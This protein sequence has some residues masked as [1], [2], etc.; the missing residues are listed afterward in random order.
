MMHEQCHQLRVQGAVDLLYLL[1][2][3][4]L[5]LSTSVCTCIVQ[6]QNGLPYTSVSGRQQSGISRRKMLLC[7][8]GVL[9]V[10]RLSTCHLQQLEDLAIQFATEQQCIPWQLACAMRS[11][12]GGVPAQQ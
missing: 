2:C 7:V 5:Y 12:C 9:S 11:A 10:G 8:C 4:F 6:Q 1:A 3:A